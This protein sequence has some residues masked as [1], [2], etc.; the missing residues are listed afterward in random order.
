MTEHFYGRVARLFL[1]KGAEEDEALTHVRV[2]LD[3]ADALRFKRRVGRLVRDIEARDSG[4]GEEYAL[5][6]GL[7]R[8]G[9]DT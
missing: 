6:I 1:I 8:T 3:A 5:V 9:S 4:I 2:R 7:Q